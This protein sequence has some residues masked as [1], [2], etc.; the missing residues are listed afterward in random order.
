MARNKKAKELYVKLNYEIPSNRLLIK[1]DGVSF[2]Y[3]R[4]LNS[5]IKNIIYKQV[6][7]ETALRAI[8]KLSYIYFIFIRDDEFYCFIRKIDIP[9]LSPTK[10]MS[11]ICS[12]FSVVFNRY[13]DE[14]SLHNAE[15]IQL[16][17]TKIIPIDQTSDLLKAIDQDL[18]MDIGN[19]IKMKCNLNDMDFPK[20]V[21]YEDLFQ[22]A[23]NYEIDLYNEFWYS[24]G[25]LISRKGTK[26]IEADHKKHWENISCMY[27]KY[28]KD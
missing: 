28:I 26:V 15:K 25:M 2:S 13:L 11:Q 6:F 23:S 21:K 14:M 1:L 5:D 17:D 16:F 10:L 4:R 20:V 27:E 12:Y 9:S 19:S 18:R 22:I 8:E 7:I 3:I 24:F